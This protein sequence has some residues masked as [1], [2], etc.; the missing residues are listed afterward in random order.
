LPGG[1]RSLTT[2]STR[3]RPAD[4]LAG[5]LLSERVGGIK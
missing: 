3:S 5:S 2:M 4:T 1:G